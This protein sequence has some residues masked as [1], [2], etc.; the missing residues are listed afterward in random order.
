MNSKKSKAASNASKYDKQSIATREEKDFL[1]QAVYWIAIFTSIFHIVANNFI[2]LSDL[3]RNSLHMGFLGT[4]CFLLYPGKK[5][6]RKGKF[7]LGLDLSLAGLIVITSLY[8]IFFE[9]DLHLRNEVLILP[10]IIFAGIAIILVLE[11]CR[12]T[13]GIVIPTLAILSLTYVLWWGQWISGVFAFRGMSLIRVLYRMY[14]TDEGLFGVIASISSTFVFM[15]ILFAAFLIKSGGANFVIDVSSRLAGRL[16]GGPGI[17]AVVA[18]G[19]MGTISGSAIANTVSTGAI[20]IPMMKR[21]GFNAK[22]AAAVEVSASTGGQLMPPI[23]GAGAFIMAQYTQL[24]YIKIIGVAIL[25]AILYYLS[26]VFQVLLTGRKYN[27]RIKPEDLDSRSLLEVLREGVHFLAPIIVLIFMLIY[28]FTPT[29]SAGFAILS[30]IVASWLSKNHKMGVKDILDAL[31]LGAKNMLT[32]GILMLSVGLIVGSLNMTG[33]SITFSSLVLEWSQGSLVI[34]LILIVLASLFLGMGLPVTAA[35]IMMAI[36]CVPALQMMGVG[37]LAAHM[38]IFWV[39]QDSNVTP[40]VCL[41]AFAG[42]AIAESPPMATGFESWKLAKGLYIIPALFVYTGL[43]GGDLSQQ[44]QV[45]FF[46]CFGLFVFAAAS[47]GELVRILPIW[48]R[49]LL[50]ANAA[51]F[52]IPELK[53]QLSGSLLFAVIFLINYRWSKAPIFLKPT[54][55]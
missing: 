12:R 32:T 39:S 36:L 48:L 23:M 46:G 4:L 6:W 8:L 45:F 15:F 43:I 26:L 31:A 54:P 55:A 7:A 51:L 42:A 17:V 29:Y 5:T 1:K 52:F 34:A 19:L 10:D 28:G 27:I 22:F 2:N 13:T 38:F 3:W 14:F 9:N 41:A 11:L 24:P 20:T 47:T 16:T 53:Y 25:P 44:L 40:P 50:M 49:F 18:S 37:L 21:A 35:Y 30:V 33:V